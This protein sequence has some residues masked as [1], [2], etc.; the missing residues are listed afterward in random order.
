[1]MSEPPSAERPERVVADLLGLLAIADQA[2]VLRERAEDVL[3]TRGAPRMAS[4]LVAREYHRL[5]V[6]S[7]TFAP[8][9]SEASLERRLSDHVLMHHLL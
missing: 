1:M 3:H 4:R 9:A 8:H 5:W 7:L 6:W 2:I